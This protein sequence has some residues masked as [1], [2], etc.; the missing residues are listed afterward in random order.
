MLLEEKNWIK[1]QEAV[2]VNRVPPRAPEQGV[3]CP[4]PLSRPQEK[5][6]AMLELARKR[7]RTQLDQ[8]HPSIQKQPS[9]H[10][11]PSL[12]TLHTCGNS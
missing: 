2:A 5:G 12:V 9:G 4:V 6:T 11:G 7:L 8:T 1:V 3:I 10:N